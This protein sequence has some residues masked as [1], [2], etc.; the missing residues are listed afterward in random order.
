MKRHLTSIG[1]KRRHLSILSY[2]DRYYVRD[3]E[4]LSFKS[5]RQYCVFRIF[6]QAPFK[7]HRIRRGTEHRCLRSM[8]AAARSNSDSN[9]HKVCFSFSLVRFFGFFRSFTIPLHLGNLEHP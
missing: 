3:K 1:L 8:Q 9:H 7:A 4:L 2:E 5:L 6:C